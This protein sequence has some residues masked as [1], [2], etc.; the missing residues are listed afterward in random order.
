MNEGEANTMG[1]S[2]YTFETLRRDREFIIYRGHH[3]SQ[4][5]THPPSI[6]A[7]TPVLERPPLASLRR[8]EHEYS[9]K[10][11]LDPGWAVRPLALASYE[12]RTMLV[13]TDPGGEPLDRLL[14]KPIELTE[15][16][17][18]A[19]GLS[20][21]LSQMHGRG[22]VHKDLKPANILV[23]RES[24]EV[25]LTGFGIASRLPRERQ[26]P[27]PPESIEGTFAY[28]APEQT[29]RMNR[30]IDSRSDLYSFGVTLY[31]MLT[32]S[33]PFTAS[34][35]ME[36][37]HCH[38][39]RKPVPPSERLEKIPTPVSHIIMK[40]LAKTAEE[41]YQTAAGV[42]SDL[43]RCLKEW[44]THGCIAD[45]LPG[46]HDASDRLLIPEKLYGRAREVETLLASFDRIVKSGAPELVL[47]SGYSGVGKSSVVHE[48]HKPLVPP[49]G[50]FAAGKFDQYK[51]E[52]PY[53]TLAQAF[54]SLVC[55]LLSKTEAELRVWRDALLEALGQ[56]GRLMVDLVPELKLIIG[57]PPPV[58]ELPPQDA[59]R[60]F[61]LVFRRFISVFARLEH[62]LALFLDDLQWLD[63]ATLDLL[64]DMLTQSDLQHLMLIGA[65]RD[66]EVT[67]VLPLMRKLEII[68]NAGGKV[69]E[70]TLA[71]LAR[72]HLGQLIA[73]ALCCDP[74]RAAPL[75]QLV[76]E[77][78]G[79]NPFFAVQFISSLG[80]EG[81]LTFDHVEGRWSWDLNRIHAKG[82]TDN[83]VDLL[84]G[85]LTRLPAETQNALQQLACLGNIAEITTVAIVLGV[86]EE[87]AHTALYPA[88]RQEL[89]E[90]LAGSYRF[91]HDRVQE[92]A[93]SL[94]P[95]ELR[96]QVHLRIGRL[97]VT[98][99]VPEKREE[100]IF[101]IVNQLNRGAGLIILGEEREQLAEL[102][103][104]AGKRAKGS[105]AYASAL[106]YL[107]AGAALLP[108]D[109]WASRHNLIFELEL[110]RAE[111]EFL[112]GALAEAEERLAALSRHA[113]NI[114]ER[115]T[116][117]CLH[118]D[119]CT[120]L[121][122]SGRA[123]AVALDYL[124]H[125]GIEWSQHPTEENAR[126][127]YEQ[128]WSHLGSRAIEDA[129]DLPLMS[130]PESLATIEVLIKLMPPAVF[131]DRN[132]L[133][134]TICRMVNLS[135]ERGNCEA[136]CFGY[137][138]L[139]KIAGPHFG[140]YQAGFRFGQ[141]GHELV[142][143]RGLKR[144]DARTYLCF[145]IFVVRW[146]S[147][148]RTGR[149]LVHRAFEAANKNGD[150]TF[151]TYCSTN[152]LSNLLFAGDPLP[153]VEGEAEHG[154]AFA[155]KAR[156][157][158]AIDFIT[159]QLALILTLRG[160]TP[161][162]GWLDGA[163]TEELRLEHHLAGNQALAIA[164][165]WYWIRKLQARF[166]AGDYEAA[167]EASSRAQRLLWTSSG[168][169]EEA[170]YHLYSALSRAA[171]C[172]SLSA[173]ARQRCLDELAAHRR[174]LEIWAQH[175]PENFE[176]RAALVG[177]ELARIEGR[178]LEAEHLYE[179]A[180]RSA[181]ANGFVH[182]EAIAYELAARFY[183]ARGFQ[184]FADAYLLEARY[185]YRRWGAD[186][187]VRQLD[188]LYPHL[189]EQEPV[190]GPTST[191][192]A[193]VEQLDLATV[194]KV[195]QAVSGEMVLERLI[196]TLMRTAIEHAGAERGLLILPRGDE[197]RIAAEATTSGDTVSVGPR[198]ASVAAAALPE[199]IVH[200]VVRTQESVILDDASAE[201]PF[202]AD[203]YLRQ[204]HARSILCLPLINQAKLGVL[205]LENNLTPH[206]FTPARISVLKLLALQAAI[207]LENT[208]LYGD[209]QEREAKIRRL[210]EANI[211]GIVIWNLEGQIIEANEA[212]LRMLGYDR[213]DLLSGRISWRELT[214]DKWRAGDEQPLA[215]LAVTGVCKPFE[216]ELFRKDG[217]RVPVLVGAASLE[218][219]GNEGVAFVLDLSEQKCSEEALRRSE[220]YLAEAQRLTHTG[221][222]A[223]RPAT[224]ERDYWSSE[225]YRIY[226]FDPA[227]DPPLRS[228]VL[229]R[230]HPD[231]R[232]RVDRK[233]KEA[234]DEET[235]FE[236]DFRIILPDGTEKHLHAVVHP[237]VEP[238]GEVVD[239][240]GTAMDVTEQY[241][242]RVALE[243][244][245]E[246]IRVL[247]DRLYK[248]NLALRDEVDRTSMF[249]EIVGT[250][251][252]MRAVLSRV[253][254]VAPTDSTV[255][256][257]GETGTGKELIARAV[258]KRS[259]RSGRA[260]VSVNC[261]AMAPSL[262]SS[263]LFGHEKGAFTGAM[264]R[265]LGRFELA[266]GGTIFLDEVGELPPDTQVALLRVLQEREFERVGGE[267]SIQVNVRVIAATN[268]DLKA[269]TASGAFREDLFY[270]LNVFPIEVPPLR[271]RKDDILMLFE[272]F[273]KRF[274][275]RAGKTIRSI[276]KNTLNL[277]QS[278]SWPGNI[279]ELQN[280]IERSV[281]LS[282]G[283]V[284][285]VDESWLP[286][287]SAPTAPRPTSARPATASVPTPVGRSSAATP[288]R[289]RTRRRR[290][291]CG[292]GTARGS[293]PS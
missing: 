289:C 154:L 116:V 88:V 188:Q 251:T 214:P 257:T 162:F 267:R 234:I 232:G 41:R 79:G 36:W 160:L 292:S 98:H 61:Q 132:L 137:V 7:M 106:N 249:E 252:A 50:L 43:R 4:I 190:P 276:D 177:A 240:V 250:S 143:R 52:I 281:I 73:D 157:G 29:G 111:C 1:L 261:A 201:N 96:A 149:D 22:L 233:F 224:P 286:K 221:T 269:A 46:Q 246:E 93:Y 47:V 75:A 198:E 84:V 213:E 192:G 260:F 85:K 39:A 147:H 183:A 131:T 48:L 110:N 68:K 76:H 59:Q 78:T 54:Q 217:S 121:D 256:I 158:L 222:Y 127:E 70:I 288:R 66:N 172:D 171:C 67:I 241:R 32:G 27:A 205:Y 291:R 135:L 167:L 15:F 104:L 218:R 235:G 82:Y 277:F 165:C 266:D 45:F 239:F 115:A 100:A 122:Q 117:A 69:A 278:Y 119:V 270:R 186:G 148:V 282:S 264:Q 265:R 51:R 159:P 210:V 24:G 81:L 151:A 11:E 204:H 108:G 161:K 226:G 30:S 71:P 280:V 28:M 118:I 64:E 130:D 169:L 156:F 180:I 42:E 207:S 113:A 38:I 89:L 112:T 155:E 74:E 203:T 244:A 83:V 138:T 97:L 120:T 187:K 271:E 230:I 220:Y 40:L 150:L 139:G 5:D 80:E 243:R 189:R 57:E 191:I 25:R 223:F 124:R 215:E 181:H 128:I 14:E 185:C 293:R 10:A 6:L 199:S 77:K 259:Q 206:V 275:S 268:R 236:D 202:S 279:R 103:L 19:I 21:A 12:G 53:A 285:S 16:L 142:E 211:I 242:N 114:V 35:P 3:R 18:T 31:Q 136:S 163:G 55:S 49:R 33:L 287:E 273:V 248:E 144:F 134:L 86:S 17:C 8:M 208:R 290:S 194:I 37:V 90:C 23:T 126:C 62:P 247:K 178:V 175:C 153:E 193:S 133:C 60:R 13:L 56:N 245:F 219:S 146:R 2:E 141:L 65:Y 229:E 101:D 105:T 263:E 237:I 258:H 272:Y 179:Q 109:S 262:I 225:Y 34:D 184:K 102:N 173:D 174:Q 95:E 197:L 72:E 254:R 125:V 58:P 182:N 200:Y 107:V 283:D 231:D 92:A 284:F 164:E 209:L 123:V 140:D 44:E 212:F 9:F 94:V 63:A 26:A 129:I 274:A 20:A 166:L 170:E 228:A 253:T 145:Q 195:S 168:F 152:L 196:D 91:V 87:Q 238:G 99:L 227:K 176:N 255:L 216:K